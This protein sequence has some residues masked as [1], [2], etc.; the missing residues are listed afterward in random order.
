MSTGAKAGVGVGVAAAGLAAVAGV[1]FLLRRRKARKQTPEVDEKTE[2][3]SKSVSDNKD[4]Y[5]STKDLPPAPLP[6]ELSNQRNSRA[7]LGDSFS[8]SAVELDSK[9]ASSDATELPAY[10]T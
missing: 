1:F 9:G 10:K 8:G 5:V 3:G 7:E 6:A 4:A 2:A